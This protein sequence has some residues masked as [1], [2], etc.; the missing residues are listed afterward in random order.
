MN[1]ISKDESGIV[2]ASKKKKKKKPDDFNSHSAFTALPGAKAA[3]ASSRQMLERALAGSA[4]EPLGMSTQVTISAPGLPPPAIP[5]PHP[6]SQINQSLKRKKRPAET[7]LPRIRQEEP[8]PPL[9][10]RPGSPADLFVPLSLQECH[11]ARTAWSSPTAIHRIRHHQRVGFAVTS[12][13]R[14]GEG[15]NTQ[16]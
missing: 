9:L 1:V 8:R 10:G 13:E 15:I 12:S 3:S 14:S 4:A 5:A 11:H 2:T 16:T 7:R 6:L